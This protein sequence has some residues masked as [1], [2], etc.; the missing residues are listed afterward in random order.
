MVKILDAGR[1]RSPRA[2]A[3]ASAVTVLLL[4]GVVLPASTVAESAPTPAVPANQA[5]TS[6]VALA[7]DPTGGDAVFYRGEDTAVYQRAFRDGVWSAQ[8]SLGGRIVGAPS[9]ARAGTTLV[10]GARGTDSVLW[11]RTADQG[12]WGPWRSAGGVLSAGPAVVGHADG[13]IDVFARGTDDALWTRTRSPDG[14]WSR[15][16]SL[17]GVL[18]SGPA[19]V[20]MDGGRLDVYVAGTDRVVWRRMRTL[21]GWSPWRSVGGQ[22]YTAPAAAPAPAGGE[23]WVFVRGTNDVLYVNTTGVHTG[24]RYL[25]GVLI[26]APGASGAAGTVD[27][28]VRG[29]DK[30][31]WSRTFRDGT[32]SRWAKAWTPAAPTPPAASLL[33]TDW[34]RIPTSSRVVALT[35]D[36]G[37]NAD[38]LPS[39][40]ATLQRKNVPATFFL[41]GEWVR[42]FPAQAN[43]VAVSGFLVGNHTDT[44][45]EPGLTALNDSQVQVEVSRA[46]TAVLLANGAETR[47]YFRFPF[48]D[49]DSRVLGIVNDMDYAAVRWTVDT[50][51]WQGTSGGMTVQKV[52]DRVLAALQPGEIVLMHVG[53][54]PTDGSMLDAAA[55]PQVID[56]IRARGYSFVPLSALAG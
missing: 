56:Q 12:V 46:Q 28:V 38:A 25:E 15:W 54:H 2:I 14:T 22:T 34:T 45:P 50:L 10:V 4:A 23:P 41:T 32:W 19:A 13:R 7:P 53:S 18:A 51:G 20:N 48:G 36:A 27:V 44:H 11:L 39:I 26:D 6:A 43:A 3:L 55:L 31:L 24:W 17:G 30:A 29:S 21:A 9:A 42:D 16:T 1:Q 49:V 35:F 5:V 52:I 47:P 8:T 40:R 37:A 33:G